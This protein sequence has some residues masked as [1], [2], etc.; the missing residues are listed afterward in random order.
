MIRFT[1]HLYV[2]KFSKRV[3]DFNLLGQ[4]S[5]WRRCL[6]KKWLHLS[7]PPVTV[8]ST[9]NRSAAMDREALRMVCSPQFWRMAIVWTL[10]LLHSYFLVFLLGRAAATPHRR[11]P[12]PG[13]DG[14]RPICVVTGVNTPAFSH[15]CLSFC[16][17]RDDVA[18]FVISGDVRAR[19]GG[20]G[21]AGAG[22]LPH[23]ARWVSPL[24]CLTAHSVE[25]V[26]CVW[27]GCLVHCHLPRTS[28]PPITITCSFLTTLCSVLV[29]EFVKPCT[30]SSARTS[31]H[32][33]PSLLFL[34]AKVSDAQCLD[35]AVNLANPLV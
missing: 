14:C 3:T 12:R 20:C 25:Q 29:A 23:R 31:E 11:R 15:V 18:R 35:I 28:N 10:S 7:Y 30:D 13:G 26:C 16:P 22:G 9:A 32:R 8:E 4:Q 19:E 1:L 17:P 2:W 5:H 34:V 27:V 6:E 21:G 33:L 24:S